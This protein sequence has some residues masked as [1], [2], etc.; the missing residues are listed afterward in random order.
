MRSGAKAS[1]IDKFHAPLRI[2]EAWEEGR[3]RQEW[4]ILPQWDRPLLE[5]E[6]N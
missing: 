3:S 2:G 1:S 6:T 4:G 5:N